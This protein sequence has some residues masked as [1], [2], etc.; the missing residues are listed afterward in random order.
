MIIFGGATLLE[1]EPWYGIVRC[2]EGARLCLVTELCRSCQLLKKRPLMKA[3][4]HQAM[5]S[6]NTSF[7]FA[8][9]EIIARKAAKGHHWIQRWILAMQNT[10]FAW[11]ICEIVA[12]LHM[13]HSPLTR[14]LSVSELLC[15]QGTMPS[16]WNL[17]ESSKT[18]A[19]YKCQL[20]CVIKRTS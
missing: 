13:L 10:A 20:V 16:D 1:E 8:S 11:Y 7:A 14:F 3:S 9:E 12:H 2:L 19:S 17:Q 4:K 18:M 15:Q 6:P 5:L